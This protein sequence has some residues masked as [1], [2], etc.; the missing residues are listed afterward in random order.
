MAD[1]NKLVIEP[2]KEFAEDGTNFARKCKKPDRKGSKERYV[3]DNLDF[4]L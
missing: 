1:I 3:E 4:L 2:L